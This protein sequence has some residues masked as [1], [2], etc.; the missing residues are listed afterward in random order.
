MRSR[1]A[2]ALVVLFAVAGCGGGGGPRIDRGDAQSSDVFELRTEFGGGFAR[3]LGSSR[4]RY[5]PR[6]RLSW[7][8]ALSP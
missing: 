1:A 5:S 3:V 2:V 7:F 6:D 4:E 8:V